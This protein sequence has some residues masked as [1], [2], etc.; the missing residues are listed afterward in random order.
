M[1]MQSKD[2]SLQNLKSV[3]THDENQGFSQSGKEGEAP[4]PKQNIFD[5]VRKI[6][7]ML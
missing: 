1:A 4:F 3:S 5:V 6:T 2:N 7:N